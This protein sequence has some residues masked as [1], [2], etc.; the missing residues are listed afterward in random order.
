MHCQPVRARVVDFAMWHAPRHLAVAHL[1]GR[2]S[3][4]SLGLEHY[5]DLAGSSIALVIFI[6]PHWLCQGQGDLTFCF[7]ICD[8]HTLAKQRSKLIPQ[9]KWE[10]ITNHPE[11]EKI[12][13]QHFYLRQWNSRVAFG[14]VQCARTPNRAHVQRGVSIWWDVLVNIAINT[15]WTVNLSSIII[16][17]FQQ[18]RLEGISTR[19]N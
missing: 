12:Y 19:H 13:N 4:R 16:S 15:L 11:N 9:R 10:H 17:S 6:S 3:Q 8:F 14:N 1:P 5:F 7:C 2:G 18:Q